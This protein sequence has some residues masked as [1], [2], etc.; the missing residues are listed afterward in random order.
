MDSLWLGAL[1]GLI[2][3]AVDLLLM[4]PLDFEDKRTAMLG[5]FADRFAIG[6]LIGASD[7]P[8]AAGLQG[9]LVGV[10]VSLPSAIITK[11]HAP[12][13]GIGAVGGLLIGLVIGQWGT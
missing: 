11:A 3:G 6:V 13:L 8:V 1:L 7:F 10:L 12:I 5:A 9:L 4:M 2:F